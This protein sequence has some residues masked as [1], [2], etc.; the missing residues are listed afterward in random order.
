MKAIHVIAAEV[1]ERRGIDP[2][3]II[4]SNEGAAKA[5][6]D[7]T[8]YLAKRLTRFSTAE[9]AEALNRTPPTISAGL[10]RVQGYVEADV[11]YA[12]ELKSFQTQLEPI[13][14]H[15]DVSDAI[16]ASLD[17]ANSKSLDR[18]E[19]SLD[20][21]ERLI[22]RVPEPVIRTARPLPVSEAIAPVAQAYRAFKNAQFSI[23]ERR[24][25]DTLDKALQNLCE[26]ET[27]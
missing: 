15:L 3:S 10:V 8:A 5:A 26:Q 1:A 4:N 13:L 16:E 24:A 17:L 25:F 22:K 14:K 21:L 9:V 6:R 27:A 11:H 20:R 18:F 19:V 12:V 23:H 7:E 2:K